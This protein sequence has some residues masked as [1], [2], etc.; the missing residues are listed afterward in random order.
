MDRSPLAHPPWNTRFVRCVPGT[1]EPVPFSASWRKPPHP[2]KA[3]PLPASPHRV[4]HHS[5]LH[6]LQ[7][8]PSLH[9]LCRPNLP[10]VAPTHLHPPPRLSRHIPS[11]RHSVVHHLL[12]RPDDNSAIMEAERTCTPCIPLARAHFYRLCYHRGANEQ[13]PTIAHAH[14]SFHARVHRFPPGYLAGISSPPRYGLHPGAS[15]LPSLLPTT[16]SSLHPLPVVS[17]STPSAQTH[18]SRTYPIL[19]TALRRTPTRPYIPVLWTHSAQTYS[20]AACAHSAIGVEQGAR[21]TNAYIAHAPPAPLFRTQWPKHN[22]NAPPLRPFTS[23]WKSRQCGVRR[24]TRPAQPL[25]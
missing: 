15:S 8:P 17:Y 22:I 21:M 23:C 14:M 20:D 19:T 13:T 2:R 11:A 3:L 7:V 9:P 1:T 12:S 10:S 6:I 25:S 4:P 5:F 16:F 24:V 18:P